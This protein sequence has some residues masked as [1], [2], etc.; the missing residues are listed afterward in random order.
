MRLIIG[1]RGESAKY[2]RRELFWPSSGFG[3]NIGVRS[4][5]A[6]ARRTGITLDSET[7]GSDRRGCLNGNRVFCVFLISGKSTEAGADAVTEA[8]NNHPN[9][10]AKML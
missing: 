6:E 8:G 5:G 7:T 2:T 10:M 4:T 9:Q 1:I 3:T